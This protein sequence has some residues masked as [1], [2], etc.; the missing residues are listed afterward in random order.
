[1]GESPAHRQS[2]TWPW[3]NSTER[4]DDNALVV[5]NTQIPLSSVRFDHELIEYEAAARLVR[6][7]AQRAATRRI[8]KRDPHR[9]RYLA[10]IPA[11]PGEPPPIPATT[12]DCQSATPP[13]RDQHDRPASL[14]PD[15]IRERTVH[16]PAF[17]NQDRPDTRS[18]ARQLP[19][20]HTY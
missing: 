1:M 5:N 7:K 14:G 20:R 13:V 6:I 15:G 8:W 4:V 10:Q 19:D 11:G 2:A 17:Q 16:F 9:P 12:P 18:L 3:S